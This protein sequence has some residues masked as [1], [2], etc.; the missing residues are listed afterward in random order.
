MRHFLLLT[1]AVGALAQDAKFYRLDFTVKE[2]E[3]NKVLSAKKYT[4]I[5]TTDEKL[6]GATIRAGSKVP[7]QTGSIQASANSP[8]VPTHFQYVDV[9]VNIDVNFIREVGGQ[10]MIRVNSEI[11]SVPASDGPIS[12][13]PLIR[14][15][16]WHS[17]TTVEIGK[18]T[19]LFS[20]D[21]LNSKRKMQLELTATLVK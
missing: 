1:F 5:S 18:A 17:T 13:Q 19:T 7:Y 4:A 11:S 10:L 6:S 8:L 12:T 3:D 21:D 9:G 15:N 2:V 16:R 14:Q 20:S